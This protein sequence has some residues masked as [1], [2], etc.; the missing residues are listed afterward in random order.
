MMKIA[1]TRPNYKTHLITPPLGIGYISSHLQSKGW[2]VLIIDGLNLGLNNQA[3]ADRC[4]DC[5]VVGI[6]CLTDF[7]LETIDLSKKL[8]AAGKIVVLGGVHPSVMPEESLRESGADYVIVGE[9]EIAMEEL[10]RTLDKRQKPDN[11]PGVYFLGC[12]NFSKRSLIDNLDELPFPDW[13]QLDPRTYQKAPHGAVIK[14]FPVAPVV[15]TRGCPYICTFCASPRFWGQRL[16]FRS[17]ENVVEEIKYLVND[18]GVKEIH[19]EDDNLT[20]NRE[21]IVK[22][23]ELIIKNNLKISWATPNGVRADKVDEELLKLM[24]KAGC[25]YIVFGVESGNQDILNNIKKKETLADIEKA[26][27]LAHKLKFM[28]QGFFILGL[29]GETEATIRNT[30]KFAKSIPLDR[31]QFLILDLLPG[32]ALWEEHKDEFIFDYNRESY[33]EPT[34][35]TATITAD[36][37]KKWQPKAFRSFFFRPKPMLAI[38]KFIR[39]SQLKF[40]LSRLKDFK[41]LKLKK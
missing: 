29:P 34:W 39:F 22:I 4:G 2:K 12:Q 10:I 1:L 5:D 37:L 38:L 7:Y 16:R 18:F 3:V 14:N 13:E 23:C 20:L 11:I 41:I 15:T 25:Y 35:V 36:A 8:K 9:G 33:H 27:I 28:T 31:A 6:T 26:V 17:P 19:F 30:I 21:H 40:I 24:K 32:S